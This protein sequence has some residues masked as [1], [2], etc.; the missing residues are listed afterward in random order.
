[1]D[2][3]KLEP[4]DI[5]QRGTTLRAGLNRKTLESDD[6]LVTDRVINSRWL[7]VTLLTKGL[8]N[9]VVREMIETI[10]SIDEVSWGGDQASVGQ[11]P[12][13]VFDRQFAIDFY[14]KPLQF[15]QV[16]TGLNQQ[17]RLW[18]KSAVDR[19]NPEKVF[20]LFCGGGNLSL[21]LTQSN[22]QLIGVESNSQAIA[23]AK[24]SLIENDLPGDNRYLCQRVDGYFQENIH[25]EADL[26]ICDPPRAGLGILSEAIFRA[27]PACVI[28]IGCDPNCFARD[29]GRFISEGFK[30]DSLA[31]FDFFPQTFHIESVAVLTR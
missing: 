23:S 29:V 3:P 26:I 10:S 27:S 20:D 6:N 30:I 24:Y 2:P 15:Q 21:G 13:F 7:I 18:V 12:F 14:S 17:M 8:S 28:L 4:S 31:C 25:V 5:R 1:M 11:A 22:R 9:H 19:I 16:N